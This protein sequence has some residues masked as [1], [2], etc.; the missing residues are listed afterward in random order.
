MQEAIELG[1][2]ICVMNKGRIE[3]VGTAEEILKH[4][5]NDFVKEFL[6]TGLPH[7][8]EEI[9][10]HAFIEKNYY[11]T[12]PV[13]YE[14]TIDEATTIDELTLILSTTPAVRVSSEH[15]KEI[16]ITQE[17]LIRYLANEKESSKEASVS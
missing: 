17:H 4:P 10:V 11:T 6:Q 8:Q 9:T 3:Q 2:R 5:A 12:E 14:N 1:D 16:V 7:Y 13:P 15:A